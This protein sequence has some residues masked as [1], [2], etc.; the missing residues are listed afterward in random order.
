[1]FIQYR[2]IT[3]QSNLTQ[4]VTTYLLTRYDKYSNSSQSDAFLADRDTRGHTM[5]SFCNTVQYVV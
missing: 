1:M 3:H 2:I 5:Y 4:S